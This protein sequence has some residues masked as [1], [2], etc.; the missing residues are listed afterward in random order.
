WKITGNDL[1]GT[2]IKKTRV[3]VRVEERKPFKVKVKVEKAEFDPLASEWIIT[4]N[5]EKMENEIMS[6]LSGR[7]R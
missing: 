2:P 4:G 7:L 1:F 6:E 5:D 3:I